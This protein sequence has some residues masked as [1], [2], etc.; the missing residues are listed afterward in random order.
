MD[1]HVTYGFPHVQSSMENS[2]QLEHANR[3][4]SVGKLDMPK[5]TGSS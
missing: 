5:L 3:V 2:S 1:K 4:L